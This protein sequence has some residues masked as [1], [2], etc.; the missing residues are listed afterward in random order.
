MIK[1]EENNVN[2]TIFDKIIE[3]YE[4]GRINE[5]EVLYNE[6]P[7]KMQQNHILL[8]N[9]FNVY[10][11]RREFDKAE[12][13]IIKAIKSTNSPYYFKDLGKIYQEKGNA[14]KAKEYFLHVLKTQP[15]NIR[16]FIIL[17]L[18]FLMKE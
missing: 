16:L 6:L 2:N 11:F 3:F 9:I 1:P 4:L 5:A 14:N 17:D 10:F 13:Y 18:L 12:E 15:D 7:L 8:S